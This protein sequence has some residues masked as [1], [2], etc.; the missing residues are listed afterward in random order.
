MEKTREGIFLR[1][2]GKKRVDP[3]ATSLKTIVDYYTNL[4]TY[5][6]TEL[7]MPAQGVLSAFDLSMGVGL[8]RTVYPVGGNYTPYFPDYNGSTDKNYSNLLSR[9]VPFRYRFKN[10]SS[11]SGKYG[12]LS[13]S[14]PYYSDPLVDSDFLNR[15]EDM[16]WVNMLK[17]STNMT[18]EEE[19]AQQNQL[20]SYTWQ[21][22]GQITPKFPRMSPYVNSISFSSISSTVSFRVVDARPNNTYD[23][24]YYSPSSYFYAPDTATLYSM[25]VSVTGTP[26]SFGGDSA[27][28]TDNKTEGTELPDPLKDIGIPRSPFETK[29]KEDAQKKAQSDKLVPPELS[30][31]FELPRTGS[32]NLS[33][34]YRLVPL[35]TSTLKFNYN[36]WK[37]Y[38]EINWGDITSIL[39]S[40]GGDASTTVNVNHS[41]G[42]FSN[43]FTYGGNGTW[44][45]YGYLNE[46]A[47][48]FLYTSGPDQGTTDPDK[49]DKAKLQEY[50]QSFFSTSYSITSTLRPVYQDP[51]FGASNLQYDL[52]G[53]AVRSKFDEENSTGNDPQWD[54]D[55][56]EWT[57][58]KIDT[59]QFSTNVSAL[60]MD[61]SQTFSAAVNLPPK[62]S[63]L[64]LRTGLRIWVTETDANMRILFPEDAEKRKVEPLYATERIIFGTYGN[65]SQS[66][67]V[68][69]E[70][71][72]TT[73]LTSSLNLTKWGLTATYAAARM[74]GYEYIPPESG[75]VNTDWV[76]KDEEERLQSRD[77]TLNYIN[78]ISMKELWSDRLQFTVNTSSR[79]FLD[80]QRYTSSTLSFSLG[81]TLGINRFID[82]SLSAN[83][84]NASVYRYFRNMPFFNDAPI[85]I[86]EG[87]QNNLLI[88]LM[89]SFR[90]DDNGL[91][92]SS[93]FKMKS[94]HIAA[95]HYLGDWNAIL[96]WT[97]SPYRP[98]DKRQYEINNEISFLVQWVPISEIK[99][100]IAY[101]KR[102]DPEWVIKQ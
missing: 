41:E 69:M 15:V 8:T 80:L 35:G 38:D 100:D 26:L 3:D 48:D 67:V 94:F 21:L 11:V 10:N 68:D 2:T 7:E 88:D 77:F 39:N 51:I 70:E 47:E 74:K 76:Q 85:D 27:S 98:P 46:E 79:L 16:D 5:I 28:R 60:V 53:L 59:H 57:D 31:R 102:N 29:E 52:K 73:S 78:N 49:I 95:T 91:R 40:F 22:S 63:E 37:Q 43:S 97:M 93:G 9:E 58:E 56:G 4:G 64:S 1:S 71:K 17:S 87:P 92:E 36:K 99:T 65:F 62:D 32:V 23:I 61:K 55:Y 13:W 50:K 14:F 84:E 30:Q 90:F 75:A 25:S 101:N 66:I 20:G 82:L 34:D 24:K 81:F 6:G 89:N 86:P 19:L 96:S 45:Q 72:E 54:L 83:S 42:F 33:L 12:G 44:R 18:E